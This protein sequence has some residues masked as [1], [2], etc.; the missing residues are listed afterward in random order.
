MVPTVTRKRLLN[1]LPSL[2]DHLEIDVEKKRYRIV[3]HVGEVSAWRQ[4]VR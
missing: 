3:N 2:V 4:V 1:L